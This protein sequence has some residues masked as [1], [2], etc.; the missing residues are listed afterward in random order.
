[1]RFFD[2]D[3]LHDEESRNIAFRFLA[4]L[5]FERALEVFRVSGWA[6]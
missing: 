1:M 3:E 2:W 4:R 6:A 5:R